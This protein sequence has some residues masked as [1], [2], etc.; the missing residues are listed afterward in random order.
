MFLGI[1]LTIEGV[2]SVCI[3]AWGLE[4]SLDFGIGDSLAFYVAA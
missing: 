1:W 4:N 2:S 3:A